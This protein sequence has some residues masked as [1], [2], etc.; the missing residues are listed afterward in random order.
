MDM[1]IDARNGTGTSLQPPSARSPT[2]AR[3][4]RWVRRVAGR[5]RGAAHSEA[6]L[7]PASTGRQG[8]RCARFRPVR[9]AGRGHRI[10]SPTY[11]ARSVAPPASSCDRPDLPLAHRLGGRSPSS[12]APR[13]MPM[14]VGPRETRSRRRRGGALGRRRHRGSQAPALRSSPRPPGTRNGD[15]RVRGAKPQRLSPPWGIGS[16]AEASRG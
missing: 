6:R 14:T 5:W 1:S 4:T 7:T 9:V 8:P 16:L 11:G 10:A 2:G 12:S 3:M 15:S 13:A